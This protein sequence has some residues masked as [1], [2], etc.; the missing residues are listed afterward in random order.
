VLGLAAMATAGASR[1]IEFPVG[2]IVEA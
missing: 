1:S 2:M